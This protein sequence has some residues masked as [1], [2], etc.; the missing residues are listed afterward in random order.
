M[1]YLYKYLIQ[2]NIFRLLFGSRFVIAAIF[3]HASLM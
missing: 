2:R 1:A 3:M